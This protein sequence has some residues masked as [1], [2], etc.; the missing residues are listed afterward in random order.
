MFA[1]GGNQQDS[2]DHE[3]DSE[4][5]FDNSRNKLLISTEFNGVKNKANTKI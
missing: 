4:Y 2:D 5:D 1:L 3:N